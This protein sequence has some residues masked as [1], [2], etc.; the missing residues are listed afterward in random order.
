MWRG[1]VVTMAAAC[2]PTPTPTPSPSPPPTGRDDDLIDVTTIVPDAVF[3]MRYATA[4][5]FTHTVLYPVARCKLR[6][7]VA[8][9]LARAADALRA[10]HRRLLLWDCYRPRSVQDVLWKLVPDPRYVAPPSAGSTHSHGAAV[11]VA[12]VAADGT[13]LALPTAFD[14]FSAAA[15]RDHALDGERGAEARRLE[16]AMTAAGFIGLPTEWW[17]FDAPDATKYPIADEPL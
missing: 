5:N 12:L 9:R 14:E 1:V 11:D 13:P 16:A 6:R 4:N 10:D 8:Q 17:H 15:H 7:G 2:S 3:D